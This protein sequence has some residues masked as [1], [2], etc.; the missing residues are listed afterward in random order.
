GKSTERRAL[1][2]NDM[3]WLAVS[4]FLVSLFDNMMD[5]CDLFRLIFEVVS[6]YGT[7]GLSLSTPDDT[8]SFVSGMSAFSKLVIMAVMMSGRHR[9]LPHSLDSAVTRIKQPTTKPQ[10][11]PLSQMRLDDFMQYTRGH[12][13]STIYSGA[14]VRFSISDSHTSVRNRFGD[15]LRRRFSMQHSRSDVNDTIMHRSR[16]DLHYATV[17]P[18]SREKLNGGCIQ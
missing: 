8:G 6:A 14:N 12:P 18:A 15:N 5:I 3:L 13:T 4:I 16:E 1:L 2:A 9:G 17:G 10:S 11:S 7:V